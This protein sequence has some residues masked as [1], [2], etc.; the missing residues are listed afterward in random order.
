MMGGRSIRIGT[1]VQWMWRVAL[2]TCVLGAGLW[3]RLSPTIVN[4]ERH[5]RRWADAQARERYGEWFT[6]NL[7]AATGQPRAALDEVEVYKEFEAYLAKHRDA[8]RAEV[9]ALAQNHVQHR[10]GASRLRLLG[11][12]SYYYFWLTERLA[13]GENPFEETR[14]H[15]YLNRGTLAPGGAWYPREYFPYLGV[16]AQRTA[17]ALGMG[18]T[19]RDAAAWIP[20][21][22]GLLAVLPVMMILARVWKVSA[23][24][25]LVA[26][27]VALL[28]PSFLSRSTLGQ[29]DTDALNVLMFALALWAVSCAMHLRGGGL[30]GRLPAA[31]AAVVIGLSSFLWRGWMLPYSLIVVALI[32]PSVAALYE[33]R[34]GGHR[35]PL[36]RSDRGSGAL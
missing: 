35:P 34:I 15:E 1:A 14:H 4:P 6:R 29:Y 16:I 5:A 36:P 21:L 22:V 20:V 30:R 12:D 25:W 28:S 27:L 23:G 17:S 18:W 26:G 11:P 24:A 2:V 8:Y 19:L 7:E 13:A 10:Y 33:H 32:I 31:F 9:D 3:F